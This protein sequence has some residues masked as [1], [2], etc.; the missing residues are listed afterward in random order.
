MDTQE[1][2]PQQQPQPESAAAPTAHICKRVFRK[3]RQ[4]TRKQQ[5]I[6]AVGALVTGVFAAA[7]LQ[8]YRGRA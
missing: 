2:Q 3:V 8:L 4:S 5:A 7:A 6:F 1:Q